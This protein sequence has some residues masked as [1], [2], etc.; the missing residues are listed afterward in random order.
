LSE[1]L[2]TRATQLI[3]KD[4]VEGLTSA[5]EE[6]LAAHLLECAECAATAK[7]T[8]DA[9]RSLRA[10]QIPLPRGLA[11]RTQFRVGLRA[12]E[13]R[14]RGPRRLALW[15]ACALSWA[16][17]IVSAPYVWR[18]FEWI[19]HETGAPKL[20]LQFGFGLWW[21][22]PASMAAVILLLGNARQADENA[23]LSERK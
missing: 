22:V 1:Q 17:G 12:Q 8:E 14:E 15:L 2:H 11:S 4:R 18:I 5:E 20:L 10:M 3:A 19:G 6:W 16:F 13:M 23:W 21:L 7:N 9:L